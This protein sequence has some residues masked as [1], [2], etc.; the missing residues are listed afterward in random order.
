MELRTTTMRIA[1]TAT[2]ASLVLASASAAVEQPCDPILVGQTDTPASDYAVAI[3]GRYAFVCDLS[4]NAFVRHGLVVLDIDNPSAPTQVGWVELPDDPWDLV[5]DAG[6]AYVAAGEDGLV[7]VDVS[8]PA[9]PVIIGARGGPTHAKGIDI[10]GH[11]AYVAGGRNDGLWIYDIADP[12]DPAVVAYLALPQDAYKVRVR[13]GLA[14][15]AALGAGLQIVD[16]GNPLAPFIVGVFDAGDP[17]NDI[18]LGDTTAVLAC[19]E[20]AGLRTIDISDPA[21]PTEIARHSFVEYRSA[22]GVTARGTIAVVGTQYG[23]HIMD[24]ADPAAPNEIGLYPL[25]GASAHRAILDGNLAYVPVRGAGPIVLD[26]TGCFDATT[27]CNAADFAPPFGVLDQADVA[28]FVG[29]FLSGD[30]AVDLDANAIHELRDLIA[31][32]DAFVSGCP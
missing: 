10:A 31:F 11:F 8:D 25:T 16:V 21:W 20:P 30:P 12:A 23:V 4:R 3:E 29:A 7:V 27:P 26:L 24:L 1:A 18:A 28:V 22:Y 9:L 17:V 5:V 6:L 19:G 14:Y 13:D 15:V 32:V 2:A